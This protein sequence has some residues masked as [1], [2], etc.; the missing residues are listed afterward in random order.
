[1]RKIQ[2]RVDR[3]SQNSSVFPIIT[4]CWQFRP[5]SSVGHHQE[6][7]KTA[8]RCER[9]NPGRKGFFRHFYLSVSLIRHR[10]IVLYQK[11]KKG[12]TLRFTIY[13]RMIYRHLGFS[14]KMFLFHSCSIDILVLDHEQI[15]S[16]P[17][18]LKSFAI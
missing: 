5:R 2:N 3:L 7:T 14:G 4:F 18:S 8:D 10:D 13:L 16:N 6:E 17:R 1:M 12:I 15:S 9:V 11:P